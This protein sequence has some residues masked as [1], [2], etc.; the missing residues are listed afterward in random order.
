M[1]T[2]PIAEW[3]LLASQRAHQG[4][5]ALGSG[6][7]WPQDIQE[8]ARYSHRRGNREKGGVQDFSMF[9]HAFCGCTFHVPRARGVRPRALDKKGVCPLL[10]EDQTPFTWVSSLV[11]LH[12]QLDLFAARPGFVCTFPSRAAS[13]CLNLKLTRPP[14]FLVICNLQVQRKNK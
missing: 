6:V 10:D 14:K 12:W 13:E 1:L 9:N 8:R 4:V 5:R 11:A 3:K 7:Q 2:I